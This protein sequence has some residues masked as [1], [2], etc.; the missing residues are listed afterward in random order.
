MELFDNVTLDMIWIK[1]FS[2]SMIGASFLDIFNTTIL[3]DIYPV[4]SW[5]FDFDWLIRPF[6]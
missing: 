2:N 5:I 6:R 1:Y 3:E 4:Y